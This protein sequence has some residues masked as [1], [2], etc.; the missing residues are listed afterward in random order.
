MIAQREQVKQI[1]NTTDPTDRWYRGRVLDMC[2]NDL[3]F[4]CRNI[5]EYELLE[6]VPHRKLARFIETGGDRIL[7]VG[8]RGIYKTTIGTVGRAIQLLL[9]DPERRILV[10][11]N[12][13]EN[14]RAI[15]H[16]VRLHFENN[17]YLRQLVPDLVPAKRHII[18]WSDSGILLN[19]KGRWS[20]PSVTAAGVETQLASR[21]YDWILAD[22]VVAANRDDMKE[23]DIIILRPEEIAKAIG[24]FKMTMRGMS[25]VK[26]NTRIQFIVNRW[27]VEDFASY[28][29]GNHLKD[30][31]NP[32]GFAFMELG[33]RT[34]N[35][36]YT[37]PSVWDE[38]GLLELR[39]E[40]KSDFL[41]FTQIECKPI[42][43]EGLRFPEEENVYW[44]PVAEHNNLPENYHDMKIF[45]LMDLA[46]KQKAANCN[47]AI[48]V[49]GVDSKGHVWSLEALR[50][51]SSPS[52]TMN[53]MFKFADKYNLP[54]F[55]VEEMVL[56]SW[57]KRALKEQCQK[58]EANLR[59]YPLK[60]K[61]R[62]KDF[63]ILGL[64]PLHAKGGLHIKKQ[65]K[66]LVQELRDFPFTHHKDLADALAYIMDIIRIP[67]VQLAAKPDPKNYDPRIM[68]GE[69][70][71]RNIRQANRRTNTGSCFRSQRRGSRRNIRL[72]S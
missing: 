49:V 21:H 60:H 34:A 47:T 23:N 24:W 31:D 2:K 13:K 6:E 12:T 39:R 67:F 19:R 10:V 29:I 45:G 48:V 22:D 33:A 71:L 68:T 63:R 4:L 65:H 57:F 7:L 38:K 15:V 72:V 59:T 8:A 37:W 40:M 32:K 35:G 61:N 55:H 56:D 44:Y 28:I 54:G 18:Q 64:Q 50:R 16:Q 3:Y 14:A 66:D 11:S 17:E 53:N 20:E 5:L 9:Q 1:Y 43:P 30:D 69:S 51:K 27:G 41:Y 58:R 42:N 52:E 25:I 36:G 62:D 26:K 70:L 46:D